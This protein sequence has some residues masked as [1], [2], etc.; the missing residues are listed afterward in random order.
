MTERIFYL[1]E[2]FRFFKKR[3]DRLLLAGLLCFAFTFTALLAFSKPHFLAESSFRQVQS[4]MSDSNSVQSMLKSMWSSSEDTLAIS[5]MQSKT[6]LGKVVEEQGLQVEALGESRVLSLLSRELRLGKEKLPFLFSDVEYNGDHTQTFFIRPL[7]AATFEV[8]DPKKKVLASGLLHQPVHMEYA[9]WTLK[10]MPLKKKYTAFQLLPK[11]TALAK[12]QKRVKIKTSRLD[13][14]LLLLKAKASHRQTAIG[15]LDS[16]MH[17]Y[18]EYLQTAHEE[19]SLEQISYLKK[20]R[21]QLGQD[22]EQA[23]EEHATYLKNTLGVE[24]FLGLAQ[25]IEMLSEPKEKYTAQKHKIDLEIKNWTHPWKEGR[26]KLNQLQWEEAKILP[27]EIATEEF[28]GIDLETAKKLHAEYGHEGDRLQLELSQLKTYQAQLKDSHFGLSALSQV[29]TDAVSQE[30]IQ[31]AA[32]VSLQLAD[33][34]NRSE[35]ERQR[36]NSTLVT[37][38]A[39]LEEHIEKKRGVLKGQLFQ[40]EKKMAGLKQRALELLLKEKEA[41]EQKLIELGEKMGE[42]PEKWRLESQL[43]LKKELNMQILEGLTQLSESKLVNS[44]LFHV[45]SKPLDR[46][47][48]PLEVEAPHLFLLSLLGTILG[49]FFFGVGSLGASF[50]KGFPLS[51]EYLRDR[52][53][54]LASSEREIV[55]RI[56]LEMDKGEKLAVIGTHWTSAMKKLMKEKGIDLYDCPKP[57]SSPEALHALSVC[58]RFLLKIQD[59]KAEDLVPFEGK[60]G[61]CVLTE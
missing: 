59:E 22:F 46:A 48:A 52:N 7:S 45:E 56:N 1:A 44:H 33:Y 49:V 42:L 51:T 58:D 37:Q 15:I 6:L 39:F 50:A 24:G 41:T 14:N 17:Q 10:Q 27:A 54:Q 3:K 26:E 60:K 2:F 5:V 57:A 47:D 61:L 29:L 8:L 36:L 28:S 30:L 4:Q 35:K 18:Q 43:K 12:L 38:K 40:L 11:R 20:R 21:D 16:I 19:L 31:K 9:T 13:S 34:A 32:E 55:E 53:F 25:E 23:L